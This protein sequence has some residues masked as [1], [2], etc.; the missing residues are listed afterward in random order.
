MLKINWL[1]NNILTIWLIIYNVL[2]LFNSSENKF[3]VFWETVIK[4]VVEF[5]IKGNGVAS[6]IEY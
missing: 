1:K 4:F 6:C 3:V 2:K 5:K